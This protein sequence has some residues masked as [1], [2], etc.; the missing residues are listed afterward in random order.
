MKACPV[1]LRSLGDG[2]ILAFEHPLAGWQLV[3][4]TVEA[5]ELPRDA[6]IRELYE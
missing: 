2:E 3:K 5:G 1:V 4:G 6:A